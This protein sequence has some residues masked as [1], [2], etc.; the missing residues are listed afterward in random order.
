MNMPYWWPWR[1]K[2][3]RE[4]EKHGAPVAALTYGTIESWKAPFI[5]YT[6]GWR[7][8]SGHHLTYEIRPCDNLLR[9][10]RIMGMQSQI[11]YETA[12]A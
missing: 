2:I 4:F 8:P 5:R 11:A 10:A 9:L 7:L 12:Q 3:V 6:M 1:E